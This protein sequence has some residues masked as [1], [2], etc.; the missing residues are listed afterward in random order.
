MTRCVLG[1]DVG[2]TSIKAALVDV[3]G[4]VLAER[5]EPTPVAQG[6]AAV[7]ER[8]RATA[9]DLAR[10]SGVS[11]VGVVVPGAV[12]PGLGV[13]I[14]AANLGW[15]DVALRS[16]LEGDTGLPVVLDHDVRAAGIAEQTFGATT[17]ADDSLLVVIGTGVAGVVRIGGQIVAGASGVAGEL[18]H[19]S[20]DPDG[21][22]CP[23]GQHGCLERYGS[24]AAISRRYAALGGAAGT[25]AEEV[26]R[27][28]SSDPAAARA[29]AE[30]VRALAIGLAAATMLLDPAVIVLA[31][32]LSDAG[33]ALLDPLRVGL[34]ERVTWRPSPLVVRSPLGARAGLLGA[35]ILAWRLLGVELT[36]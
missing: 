24:A 10:E 7:V 4:R 1:I 8:L 13:A 34:A 32:G 2:G 22:A 23:C 6:P 12:D 31:G 9:N 19:V 30:A 17:G 21:E 36:S 25:P 11:A 35:A 28:R 5:V 15:R 26:A 20:V 3:N 27:R 29:W 18:G 33:D 14:F 16:L